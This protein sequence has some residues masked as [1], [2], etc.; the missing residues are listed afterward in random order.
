[1]QALVHREPGQRALRRPAEARR[2]EVRGQ[3]LPDAEQQLVAVAGRGGDPGGAL[4]DPY[5]QVE[6]GGVARVRGTQLGDRHRHKT[7]DRT[8]LAREPALAGQPV[9]EQG[10]QRSEERRRVGG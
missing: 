8:P 5:Q 9:V 2:R 1:M 3:G 4:F 10:R 7:G 6:Q